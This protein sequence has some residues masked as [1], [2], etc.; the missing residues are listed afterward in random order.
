MTGGLGSDSLDL[1]L[2]LLNARLVN[3]KTFII[4]D[5]ILDE[6]A[7]LVCIMETWLEEVGGL[8]FFSFVHQI[9]RCCSI[10]DCMDGEG[11]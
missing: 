1:K 6:E 10:H 3:S 5:L 7:D 9:S 8:G 2:L 4:S 11:E